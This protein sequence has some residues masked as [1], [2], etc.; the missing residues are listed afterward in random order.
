MSGS[1]ELSDN[2]VEKI[3]KIEISF[4]NELKDHFVM[5]MK[6][7]QWAHFHSDMMDVYDNGIKVC[8]EFYETED[9][10]QLIK[11]LLAN[12]FDGSVF[13]I[14]PYVLNN[15]EAL[16]LVEELEKEWMEIGEYVCDKCEQS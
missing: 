6:G 2:L 10:V 3:K 1:A 15:P 9:S 11:N 12:G 16:K 14:K 5:S 7:G 4:I 13:S 8:E